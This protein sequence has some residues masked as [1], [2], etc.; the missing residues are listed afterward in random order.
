MRWPTP[1]HL[2]VRVIQAVHQM[3]IPRATGTGAHGQF[4]CELRLGAGRKGG[5]LLMPHMDPIDATVGGAAGFPYG[6]HQRIQAI[7]NNAVDAPH[8]RCLQ[9]FDELT[10]KFLGHVA[11]LLQLVLRVGYWPI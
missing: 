4:P 6:V 1:E 9:L 7:P 8:S 2:S 11:L 5:G 10:G 3:Q